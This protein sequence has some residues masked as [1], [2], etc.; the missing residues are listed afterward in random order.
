MASSTEH[1]PPSSLDVKPVD[2]KQV[3]VIV[4]AYNRASFLPLCIRSIKACGYPNTEIIVVDDGS[5]DD[6]QSVIERLQPG[7]TYI[8]QKNKG[9]PG[10]RNTGI[11]ASKGNYIAYLDSDDQW[12]PGQLNALVDVLERHP[13]VGLVFA[14]AMVGNERDGFVPWYR[15]AGRD[16]FYDLPSEI[17]SPDI[18]VFH[19]F[20]F[21]RLMLNR[22]LVFTGA[23][24]IRRHLVLDCGMFDERLR[25]GEDWEVWLRLMHKTHFAS[26]PNV[27]AMYLKHEGAMTTDEDF[28]GRAW[29]DAMLLHREKSKSLELSDALRSDLDLAVQATLFQHAYAAYNRS[30][31]RVAR[32][33]FERLLM[34][35][36]SHSRGRLLWRFCS[37]PSGAISAFR[38]LKQW[39]VPWL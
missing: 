8:H 25:T 37:L 21:Y 31:F 1:I 9:L 7:I 24:L 14:D 36:P 28:M 33:R 30:D 4:P 35:Y 39:L 20:P 29:C 6:T 12:F 34:Y 11:R 18:R 26:I 32:E 5:T 22:N 23:V 27:L 3:S 38:T 16:E 19:R 2:A 15:F 13:D 10:A 17:R